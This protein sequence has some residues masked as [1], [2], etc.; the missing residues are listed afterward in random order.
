MSAYR[1]YP[2]WLLSSSVD[3]G[4]ASCWLSCHFL[5]EIRLAISNTNCGCLVIIRVGAQVGCCPV[6]GAPSPGCA[7]LEFEEKF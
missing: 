3:A 6:T 7:L 5:P 2:P 4:I 1:D